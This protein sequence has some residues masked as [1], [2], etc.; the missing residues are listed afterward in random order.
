MPA[1][2][3]GLFGRG[4]HASCMIRIAKSGNFK[5]FGGTGKLIY[6]CFL[7][8]MCKYIVAWHTKFVLQ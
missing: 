2:T 7:V 3:N 5:P 1:T 6:V 4:E 8:N